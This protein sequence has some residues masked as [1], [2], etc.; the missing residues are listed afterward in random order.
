[1]DEEMDA[2]LLSD[3]A[4]ALEKAAVAPE[5][6]AAVL[7]PAPD[8]PARTEPPGAPAAPAVDAA[9]FGAAEYH[10]QASTKKRARPSKSGKSS[11]MRDGEGGEDDDFEAGTTGGVSRGSAW[12]KPKKPAPEKPAQT[13]AA[14]EEQ[15]E[16]GAAAALAADAPIMVRIMGALAAAGGPMRAAE[17]AAK[18]GAPKSEVNSELYKMAALKAAVKH[19]GAGGAPTW[20]LPGG[21]EAASTADVGAE[22]GVNAGAGTEVSASRGGA[23]STSGRA[24]AKSKATPKV[25]Q[26]C[27]TNVADLGRN[28]FLRVRTYA[29]KPLVD[30]REFYEKDSKLHPGKKGCS[31]SAERWAALKGHAAKVDEVVEAGIGAEDAV[32]CWLDAKWRLAVR[33]WHNRTLIDVREFYEKDNKKLPGKK[34]ISLSPD[35]WAIVRDNIAAVDAAIEAL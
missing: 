10:S 28:R 34:G 29:G 21:P 14:V 16:A 18:V 33:Q 22:G 25:E 19:A 4:E 13:E 2:W 6:A 1:M 17:L 35:E 11:S 27:D 5:K 32:V 30:V 3:E 26:D 31:L 9:M 7:V 8:A 23:A 24:A 15:T 12:K 20:G